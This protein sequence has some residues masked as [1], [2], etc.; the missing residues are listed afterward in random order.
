MCFA[1]AFA[2]RCALAPLGAVQCLTTLYHTPLPCA[3]AMRT[4]ASL[5]PSDR[6]FGFRRYPRIPYK[7]Y[8][9]V[10]NHKNIRKSFIYHAGFGIMY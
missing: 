9:I 7:M 10:N 2:S 1:H 3:I 5:I 6:F 8:G 4:D